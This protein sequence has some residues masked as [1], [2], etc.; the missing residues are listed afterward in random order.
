MDWEVRYLFPHSFIH[1]KI[2]SPIEEEDRIEN[3][4]TK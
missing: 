2:G 1:A 3:S 4:V